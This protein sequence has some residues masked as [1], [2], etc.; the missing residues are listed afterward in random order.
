[1]IKFWERLRRFRTEK[2]IKQ[3]ETAERLGMQLRSYQHYEG[4]ER[5][6]DYEGLVALKEAGGIRNFLS[7][8]LPQLP[9]CGSKREQRCIRNHPQHQ[10]PATTGLRQQKR[11]RRASGNSP[12][13]CNYHMRLSDPSP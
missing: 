4:G 1:M 11:S 3:R 2:H 5:R 8:N 9:M 13:F 7:T 12:N 10:P 6:P